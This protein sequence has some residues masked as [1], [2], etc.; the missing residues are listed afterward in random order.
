MNSKVRDFR[1][2]FRSLAVDPPPVAAALIDQSFLFP[3][4]ALFGPTVAVVIVHRTMPQTSGPVELKNWF[5]LSPALL[6]WCIL[7]VLFPLALLFQ[8]VEGTT[9]RSDAGLAPRS[10]AVELG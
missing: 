6:A 3:L 10:H 9:L 2:K 1:E 8:C 5:R 7:A 4:L